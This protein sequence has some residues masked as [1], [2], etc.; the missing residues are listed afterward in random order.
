MNTIN[1]AKVHNQLVI[2]ECNSVTLL[3]K[4]AASSSEADGKG[5]QQSRSGSISMQSGSSSLAIGE[6]Q[7]GNRGAAALHR[8]LSGAGLLT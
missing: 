1:V 2:Q 8:E 6:Q 3:H 4:L 5:E 7:L